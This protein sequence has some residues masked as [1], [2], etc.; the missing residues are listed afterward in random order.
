[1]GERSEYDRRYPGAGPKCAISCKV[2]T[3]E[4]K[5]VYSRLAGGHQYMPSRPGYKV[6]MNE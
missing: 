6:V 2:I 3:M 4:G 1:M 5:S